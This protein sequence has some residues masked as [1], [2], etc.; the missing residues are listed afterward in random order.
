[1]QLTYT[2]RK[3]TS[4]CLGKGEGGTDKGMGKLWGDG[5]AHYIHYGDGFTGLHICQTR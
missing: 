1:M 5:Y 3:Q 2:D 4:Y